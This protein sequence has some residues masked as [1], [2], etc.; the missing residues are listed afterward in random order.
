M[1]GMSS[2]LQAPKIGR[3]TRLMTAKERVLKEAPGWSEATAVA[4]LRVAER[5]EA[6][7]EAD[8]ELGTLVDDEADEILAGL[9]AR[10]DK[11]TTES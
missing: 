8:Q 1:E 2:P 11:A 6:R 10:E 3:Y 5:L 4:V 7:P 9:D